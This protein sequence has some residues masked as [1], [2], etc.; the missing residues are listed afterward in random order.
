M[1][2]TAAKVLN[3]LG[4]SYQMSLNGWESL[5]YQTSSKYGWDSRCS[6]PNLI[7]DCQE[8]LQAQEMGQAIATA[9]MHPWAAARWLLPWRAATTSPSGWTKQAK[10]SRDA[11]WPCGSLIFNVLNIWEV[12]WVV[13]NPS[14][15]IWS[16][17]ERLC[18]VPLLDKVSQLILS[19]ECWLKQLTDWHRFA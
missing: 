12:L 17:L 13:M 19:E 11:L 4:K 9:G 16:F 14:N 2:C 10:P 7:S 1:I 6:M 18:L 5:G 15:T 3:I 8:C